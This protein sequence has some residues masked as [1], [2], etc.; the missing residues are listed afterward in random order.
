MLVRTYRGNITKASRK[1]EEGA[2]LCPEP[3]GHAGL[4]TGKASP[5]ALLLTSF[6]DWVLGRPPPYY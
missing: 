1:E 2:G 6:D 3:D 5:A 4:G